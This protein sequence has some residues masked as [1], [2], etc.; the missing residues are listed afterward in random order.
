MVTVVA[1]LAA[2]TLFPP[3]SG[4]MTL[5]PVWPGAGHALAARA[6][7]AGAQLVDRG[8]LP[9]SLVISGARSAIAPVMLSGGVLVLSALGAGCGTAAK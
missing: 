8:P 4:T 7:D 1:S 5:I 6:I 2:I 9:G 3:S